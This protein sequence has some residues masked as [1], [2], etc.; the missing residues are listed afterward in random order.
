MDLFL[1]FVEMAPYISAIMS[2]LV[3]HHAKGASAVELL[4][5]TGNMNPKLGVPL[6]LVILFYNNIICAE[7]Q[8]IDYHWMLVRYIKL[9]FKVIVVG[10]PFFS[11][12]L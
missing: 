12:H 9:I 5:V 6:L 2:V 1:S 8:A 10:K 4:A 3:L 11:C 7:D